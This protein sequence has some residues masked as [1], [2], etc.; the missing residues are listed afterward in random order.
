MNSLYQT[1][2]NSP[3][4]PHDYIYDALAGV[5]GDQI[6]NQ[7]DE[8]YVQVSCDYNLHPDDD[9]EKAI[10]LMVSIMEDDK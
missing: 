9:F 1:I 6:R 10:D 5:Y 7:L 4:G 2:L 8:L 3:V